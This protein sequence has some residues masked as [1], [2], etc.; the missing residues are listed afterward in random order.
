M[1]NIIKAL[2]YMHFV[3]YLRLFDY[4]VLI[5]SPNSKPMQWTTEFVQHRYNNVH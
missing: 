2:P 1:K 5:L 4:R 3:L